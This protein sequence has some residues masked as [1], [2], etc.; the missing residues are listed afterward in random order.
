M[1]D[2]YRLDGRLP[3][4]CDLPEWYASMAETGRTV[5]YD[6]LGELVVSTVFLGLNQNSG[7]GEPLLFET[8][9]FADEHIERIEHY[10]ALFRTWTEAAEGHATAVSWAGAELQLLRFR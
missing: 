3:V 4:A 8:R 9:V 7:F 5:G 1:S 2:L 10:H 6:R